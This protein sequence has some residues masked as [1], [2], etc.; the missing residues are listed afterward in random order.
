MEEFEERYYTKLGWYRNNACD[1]CLGPLI[2]PVVLVEGETWKTLLHVVTFD[3]LGRDFKFSNASK[4]VH[5]VGFPHDLL[6]RWMK[7]VALATRVEK[8]EA[9]FWTASFAPCSFA[10]VIAARR[11]TLAA[12]FGCDFSYLASDTNV[13]GDAPRTTIRRGRGVRQHP[14]EK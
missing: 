5:V 6:S 4:L 8:S 13:R 1:K 14:E 3:E 2:T 7:E 11:R 12:S 9:I 10:T